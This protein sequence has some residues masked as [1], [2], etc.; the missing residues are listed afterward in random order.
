M[1][2]FIACLILWGD[3]TRLFSSYGLGQSAK[4]V[5]NGSNMQAGLLL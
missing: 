3:L 2:E 5:A 1:G 4:N